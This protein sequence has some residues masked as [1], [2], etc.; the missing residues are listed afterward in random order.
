MT[1]LKDLN[2]HLVMSVAYV[3]AECDLKSALVSLRARNPTLGTVKLHALLLAEH[4][5][6]TASEKRT[7]KILQHEGLVLGP[8]LSNKTVADNVASPFPISDVVEGLDVAKWTSKV[9][10]KYFGRNKG[11]GLVAKESIREGETLWK[12]DPFILAPEWYDIHP[13]SSKPWKMH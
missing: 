7:K 2:F 10:V 9:A 11:K 3:P 12:E 5:E 1:T 8:C 6:W 4:P 13:I